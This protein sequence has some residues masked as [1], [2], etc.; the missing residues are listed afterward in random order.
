MGE[1]LW[2]SLSLSS[3][4]FA[5][6]MSVAWSKYKEC[7]KWPDKETKQW[8]WLTTWCSTRKEPYHQRPRST[9]STTN[10]ATSS[11]TNGATSSTNDD[12]WTTNDDARTTTK[13]N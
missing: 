12:E 7:K 1:A 6:V 13:T 10:D 9:S 11:T 4:L 3:F 8:L 2:L 5:L